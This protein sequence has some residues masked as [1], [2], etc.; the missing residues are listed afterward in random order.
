MANQCP[1]SRI[2]LR[3]RFAWHSCSVGTASGLLSPW[4]ARFLYW[5]GYASAPGCLDITIPLLRKATEENCSA[6]YIFSVLTCIFAPA[7]PRKP[8]DFLIVRENEI[9]EW[10]FL[11]RGTSSIIESSRDILQARWAIFD[12]GDRIAQFGKLNSTSDVHLD[13][14]RQNIKNNSQHAER[15]GVYMGLLTG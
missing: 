2:H 8:E 6:L 15:A 11:L 5:T 7:S 1:T 4:K 14:L 3:I 12:V 13:E 10:L 9:A